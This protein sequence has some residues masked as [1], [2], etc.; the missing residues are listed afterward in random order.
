MS[1]TCIYCNSSKPVSEFY[2]HP[3]TADG[4]LGGCKECVKLRNRANRSKKRTYYREYDARRYQEDPERRAHAART[5]ETWRKTE[6]GKLVARK[7]RELQAD[8]Y[9]ARN[10]VNNAVRDGRLKRQPCSVCGA[11]L[12]IHAHHDDYSKPLDVIWLCA[13]HHA[14]LHRNLGKSPRMSSAKL[15]QK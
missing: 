7:R 14:E 11:K 12:R 2:K 4:R 3:S 8:R 10:S 15:V 5:Y 9:K 6:R 13:K 1:K